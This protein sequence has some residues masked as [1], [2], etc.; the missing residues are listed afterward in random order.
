MKINKYTV[1]RLITT[2]E[3]QAFTISAI[4]NLSVGLYLTGGLYI[5][6]EENP[7]LR[8]FHVAILA[9]ISGVAFT[10]IAFGLLV[11]KLGTATLLRKAIV[12][13]YTI[14]LASSDVGTNHNSQEFFNLDANFNSQVTYNLD[15]NYK[16]DSK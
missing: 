4:T 6:I 2:L 10:F 7:P 16:Q 12:D 5:A 11:A 3:L 8:G 15:L 14:K 9:I 1:D 13:K